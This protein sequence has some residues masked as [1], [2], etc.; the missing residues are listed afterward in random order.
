[1]SH[2]LPTPLP[3][4]FGT[5]LPPPQRAQGEEPMLGRPK[6]VV[7]ADPAL[8]TAL[9]NVLHGL[10]VLDTTLSIAPATE[11]ENQHADH[12]WAT[13]RPYPSSIVSVCLDGVH[14]APGPPPPLRAGGPQPQLVHVDR[15]MIPGSGIYHYNQEPRSGIKL[16]RLQDLEGWGKWIWLWDGEKTP[17]PDDERPRQYLESRH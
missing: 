14:P 16:R 15:G 17:E 2:L 9:N 10:G 13:A 5:P 8:A 11:Q 4:G 1:L 6:R 7:A 12:L 3:Q